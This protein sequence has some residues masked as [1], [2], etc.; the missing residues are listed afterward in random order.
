[1]GLDK[2]VN[3]TLNMASIRIISQCLAFVDNG[4]GYPTVPHEDIHFVSESFLNF[5][6]KE[7]NNNEN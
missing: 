5:L 4:T 3:I 7:D 2:V 6:F 1:M